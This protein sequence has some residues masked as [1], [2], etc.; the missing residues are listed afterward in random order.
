MGKDFA[1]EEV[2][3]V[4]FTKGAEDKLEMKRTIFIARG[5]KA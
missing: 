5:T 3:N 2:A 4:S 1:I